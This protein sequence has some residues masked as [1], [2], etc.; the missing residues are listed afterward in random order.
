MTD[1]YIYK[2]CFP[3]GTASRGGDVIHSPQ[4]DLDSSPDP[5]QGS[6]DKRIKLPK[7]N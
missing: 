6:K 3:I 1:I 2:K 5:N 4:G 7:L